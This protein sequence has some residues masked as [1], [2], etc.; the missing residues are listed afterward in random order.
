VDG[1]TCGASQLL[2]ERIALQDPDDTAG[3]DK[4]VVVDGGQIIKGGAG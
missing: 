1:C 4:P 2:H 3:M